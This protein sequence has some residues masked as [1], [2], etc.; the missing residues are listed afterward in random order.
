MTPV[1]PSAS[2]AAPAPAP[3][4]AAGPSLLRRVQAWLAG[5]LEVSAQAPWWLW[6]WRLLVR[7]ATPGAGMFSNLLRGVYR[8]FGALWWCW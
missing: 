1:H 8:L 4:P 5:L 3:A 6:L 2:S 7:P